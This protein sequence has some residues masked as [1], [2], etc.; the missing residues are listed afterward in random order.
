M[1]RMQAV[2]GKLKKIEEQALN[3]ELLNKP[4][5]TATL[6]QIIVPTLPLIS[7]GVAAVTKAET[8]S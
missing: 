5:F 3:F 6:L 8:P 7:K 4:N 2:I 1:P